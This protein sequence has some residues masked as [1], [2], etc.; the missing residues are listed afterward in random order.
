[1][2]TYGKTHG[3]VYSSP[4]AWYPPIFFLWDRFN[5]YPSQNTKNA[6]P[7]GLK[8]EISI[9][10]ALATVGVKPWLAISYATDNYEIFKKITL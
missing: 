10:V 1:M 7:A 4:E 9:S 2:H 6:I 3:G 8:L 5:N